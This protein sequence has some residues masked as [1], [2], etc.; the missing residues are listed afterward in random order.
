[1]LS[2]LAILA[3]LFLQPAQP[4]LVGF[5][6]WLAMLTVEVLRHTTSL[7]KDSFKKLQDA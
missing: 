1:M 5:R 6:V 4:L 2:L 3:H 7:V